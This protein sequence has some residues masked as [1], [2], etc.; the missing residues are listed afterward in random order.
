[1]KDKAKNFIKNLSN[2]PVKF[3][4]TFIMCVV[5]A[6]LSASIT[7]G[8]LYGKLG[9]R[10]GFK[11][12]QTLMEMTNAIT[13]NYI[14]EAD[15]AAMKNAAGSAMIGSLGDKW[16]Y[17]MSPS[18]YDAYK[19]HSANEYAGI[20][21]TL[22]KD[23][24]TGGFK[25]S[26]VKENTPA[27]KAG[28]TAGLVIVS[29]DGEDT[30]SLTVD[31]IRELIQSK[32]NSVIKLG[33]ADGKDVKEY[34]V[35]CSVIYSNPVSYELKEN[36]VGYVKI[37]NFD[38]GSGEA[39]INAVE[40][41]IAQGAKSLLFDVRGNGGGFLSELIKILDYLLP[42][43][44]LFVSV[45][46]DGNRSVTKSDNVCLEMKMAVLINE[47]TYSAA[48]YFAA[49]LSEYGWAST[50]GAPTTGKGRSQTT[51]ELSDG[52]AVH[53]SNR[54]YLTPNGVDLAA[55][56]GITPDVPAYNTDDKNDVQ[57]FKAMDILY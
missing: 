8:V 53:I 34:S 1:M 50:V 2:L 39:S 5:F 30:T 7:T 44:D 4:W 41:L 20:G 33:V 29:V 11:T 51:I 47:S 54:T 32:V 21:I 48:E 3:K 31:G 9:G 52:S 26:S 13:D 27:Q 17:Y 18:E 40:S 24:K 25:I 37:A 28:L 15:M 16:S 46:K 42:E 38:A 56:G 23:E 10:S 49:V 43:G 57:L 19:L 12:A 6:V 45:D 14:G 22:V 55:Q 36:S 35:D